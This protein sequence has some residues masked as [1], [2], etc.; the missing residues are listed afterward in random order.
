MGYVSVESKGALLSTLTGLLEDNSCYY[1]SIA[2]TVE[3][4]YNDH[5]GT[6]VSSV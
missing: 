4:Q 2:T 3:P 5:F 6:R 1:C